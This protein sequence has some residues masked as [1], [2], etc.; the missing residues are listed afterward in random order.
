MLV[1]WSQARPRNGASITPPMLQ[2]REVDAVSSLASFSRRDGTHQVARS[3]IYLR[4]RL[5]TVAIQRQW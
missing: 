2:E 5:E 4:C 1:Y 3:G